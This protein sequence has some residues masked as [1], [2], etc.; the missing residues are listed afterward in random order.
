MRISS[1][2]V[3]LVFSFLTIT[4]SAKVVGNEVEYTSD[5]VTM[6]GYMAYDDS[7]EGK[8]PGVL[9][10][11]EWWGHNDY[12]RAR[13]DKLAALGYTALAVDMYGDGKT[14][15]HPEKALELSGAV[16]SNLDMAE[17]RFQAAMDYLKQ[18]PTVNPEYM[19]AI[20][21]CFGGGVVLNMALRGVDLDGVAS[22]HGILPQEAPENAKPTADIVVFHGG[23]DPFVPRDKFDKF[24][25]IM[26]DTGANYEIVVYPGVKHS[27]TNPDADKY[28]KQF[29][30]PLVYD[31]DAD[32][33]S[34][35]QTQAFLNRIFQPENN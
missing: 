12:A 30:L 14:A 9:V 32:E 24:K 21:Y 27:F 1:L 19:A 28:G 10:V 33:K 20:G 18:Q 35:E 8:R 34:W 29:D 15:D 5:G 23:D 6:K 31:K 2:F 17:K 13:A 25:K 7:V 11:H 26:Q 22:F 3:L 4:A 16:M